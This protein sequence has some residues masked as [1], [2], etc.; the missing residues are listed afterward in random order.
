MTSQHMLLLWASKTHHT[1][2]IHFNI[3]FYSTQWADVFREGPGDDLRTGMYCLSK[4]CSPG[5][6][7]GPGF[8]MVAWGNHHKVWK[9]SYMQHDLT[10]ISK[11][12]DIIVPPN[13][14]MLWCEQWWLNVRAIIITMLQKLTI[15]T[16][17]NWWA[18]KVRDLCYSIE[19]L[20]VMLFPRGKIHGKN[21]C[22][23]HHFHTGKCVATAR[24]IHTSALLPAPDFYTTGTNICQGL[25]THWVVPNHHDTT[26]L[27]SKKSYVSWCWWSRSMLA[28]VYLAN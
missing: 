16:Q 26:F 4:Y 3:S 1:H 10:W 23:C 24:T 14:L 13:A 7:F 9:L 6:Q 20:H 12:T 28:I 18:Y 5:V 15:L 19:R 2:T 11:S 27:T 22:T 8:L 25:P 21:G 17:N